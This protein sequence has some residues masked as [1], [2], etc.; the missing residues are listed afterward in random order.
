MSPRDIFPIY[1]LATAL[2][3]GSGPGVLSGLLTRALLR[4]RALRPMLIGL[5]LLIGLAAFFV[6]V[7]LDFRLFRPKDVVEEV[8]NGRV[9]IYIYHSIHQRPAWLGP[10]A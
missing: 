1:L 8:V 2:A 4:A 9:V 10:V 6:G 5:D 3:V 7:H